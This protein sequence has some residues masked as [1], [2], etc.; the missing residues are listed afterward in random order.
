MSPSPRKASYSKKRAYK[1]SIHR[2][3]GRIQKHGKKY[4]ADAFKTSKEIPFAVL[5]YSLP[6]QP[7]VLFEAVVL[8]RSRKK[9]ARPYT[10]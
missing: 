8:L 6:T 4:P 1:E 9:R 10:S 2:I 7:T 5:F 3:L